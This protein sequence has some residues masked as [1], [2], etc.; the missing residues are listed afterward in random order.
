MRVMV[1]RNQ[2]T[3]GDGTFDP[4]RAR[5]DKRTGYGHDVDYHLTDTGTAF[6]HLSGTIGKILLTRLVDLDW[7]RRTTAHRAASPAPSRPNRPRRL[8]Q[9]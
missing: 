4:D 5:R 1:D 3:D 6:H 9:S 7:L 8:L 2:L